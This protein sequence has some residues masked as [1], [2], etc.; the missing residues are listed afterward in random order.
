MRKVR[1]VHD[2]R[3]ESVMVFRESSF[4]EFSEYIKRTEKK[5]ICYGAGMLPR[6]IEPFLHNQGLASHISLFIDRDLCK[7]GRTLQYAGRDLRIE[8]PEYLE[9]LDAERYVILITA[10]KYRE[11][12]KNLANIGFSSQWECYAYPVLNLDY[13]QRIERENIFSNAPSQMP[14]AIHYTWFGGREKS[15]LQKK[16]IESWHICCPDFEIQEW[17]EGN[18]DIHKNQY[19]E[20]A[21]ENHKWAYVSDYARLDILHQ[22]GGIYLD[23]DVEL[24]G[25]LSPL[26]NTRAFICFGEWPV[27]NSGAGMG[28]IKGEE[29]LKE[30]MAT[31][32]K[33]PFIQ[34]GGQLDPCTNSNYEMQVLMRRQFHMDAT[35]QQ[36]NGIALYP[37]DIIA[38]MSLVGE[39]AFVTERSLGIHYCLNTWRN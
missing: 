18:Y 22:H 21:Y 20:Q 13:F 24:F 5:V 12:Q 35:F 39:R 11:I 38:P 16:C 28:S 19:M 29:L 37:P 23:T 17:N 15:E 14:K 4:H 3:S 36:K 34:D 10:E 9:K 26:L 2:K 27:P 6:Y 31:R 32:E 7:R 25:S 30:L 1:L 8:A 33:I